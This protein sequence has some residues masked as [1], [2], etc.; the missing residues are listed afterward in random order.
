MRKKTFYP[1]TTSQ[2]LLMVTDK[3][4][5]KGSWMNI[6][7]ILN[8]EQEI[9]ENVM[10]EAIRVSM[11]RNPCT[12]IRL[13]KSPI[14]RISHFI[15]NPTLYISDKE[16]E[17]IEL[18]DYSS[19]SDEDF[20]KLAEKWAQTTFP[21]RGIETQLYQIKLIRRGE[22]K[23]CLFVNFH[24]MG[25]DSYAIM[26]IIKYIGRTYAALLHGTE[27]P[28]ESGSPIHMYEQENAYTGSE[29]EKKD[30]EFWREYYSPDDEP[31]YANLYGKGSKFHIE[32]TRRGT[33]TLLFKND[34]FHLNLPISPSIVS[35]VNKL[36]EEWHIS[37]QSIHLLALHTYM[38]YLNE[39]DDLLTFVA[40]AR[41][42]TLVQ[43][44][45]G[46]TMINSV[47]ARTKIPPE[48]TTFK[49][50]CIATN[51]AL[52]KT[53]RHH[54]TTVFEANKI[55]NEAYGGS[56]LEGYQCSVFC[57][58][59]Y[60]DMKD[61]D[62]T[63]TFKRLNNGAAPVSFSITIMACDTSG[64]LTVNY[65]VMKAYYTPDMVE[66]YHNFMVKFLDNAC[67]NPD[68]TLTEIT[69]ASL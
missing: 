2:K 51:L 17:G 60:F 44:R 9:D 48:T 16:P 53:F 52:N 55:V 6:A 29:T 61:F 54:S 22:N 5:F 35:K 14:T 28:K 65:E 40:L 45:G 57:Y 15:G 23:H 68:K 47:P 24:H 59:P 13:H 18:L 43:K 20:E 26:D 7:A 30:L 11:L 49:D 66:K 38:G 64:G 50:A 67:D 56:G 12:R 27:L 32:G 33:V 34:S 37:Q 41:R 21:H 63:Y 8:I 25:F 69:K 46:G 31:C 10:L 4:I 3:L 36:A 62:I 58:Q 42:A 39:T 1:L 19:L